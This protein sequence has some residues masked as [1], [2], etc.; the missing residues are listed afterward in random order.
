MTTLIKSLFKGKKTINKITPKLANNIA[1]KVPAISLTIDDI[2]T[3]IHLRAKRGHYWT[4]MIQV[5]ENIIMQLQT[6]GWDVNVINENP[7]SGKF[8]IRISWSYINIKT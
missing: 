8:F 1:K 3:D 5:D 4:A 2:Y 6:E 7:K